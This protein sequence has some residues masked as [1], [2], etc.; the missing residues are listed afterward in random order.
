MEITPEI[1]TMVV[2]AIVT[3]IFGILAKKFEWK[4]EDYIPAQNFAIGLIAGLFVYFLGFN[5]NIVNAIIICIF[6]A[7]TAGG[8]YDLSK[9]KK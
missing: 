3:W 7:F 4:T 2:T 8:V 1:I 9:T 6:S 5:G